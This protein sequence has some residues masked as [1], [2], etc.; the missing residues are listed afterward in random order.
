MSVKHLQ[1]DMG[2]YSDVQK[3]F[4]MCLQRFGQVDVLINNAGISVVGLSGYGRKWWH[5]GYVTLT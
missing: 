2:N 4:D 1:G 5:R 3:M